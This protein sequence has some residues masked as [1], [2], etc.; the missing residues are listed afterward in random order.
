MSRRLFMYASLLM[1]VIA[2]VISPLFSSS[3]ARAAIA[4][5]PDTVSAEKAR[6]LNGE[7]IV[8]L[9]SL[10]DGVTGVSGKIYIA[11]PP[12]KVWEVLTDYNNH[13]NF[14]PKLTDSGLISDN[15]VE[16]V[17]FQRGTTSIFLFRK[18]V[19]IQVRIRGEYLRHLD[20]QKITGDF[21]VYKGRWML[22]AYPKGHGTFLSYESE[23]KPDFFAPSFVVRFVQK[24]DFPGVLSGMKVRAESQAISDTHSVQSR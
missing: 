17:M 9:S 4:T 20:F 15:G 5:V 24:H 13:K 18:S 3:G 8:V 11:A 7:V 19:Y 23:V 1:T 14:I 10:D 22:E 6:L 2:I 21:K 12:E 16:Q